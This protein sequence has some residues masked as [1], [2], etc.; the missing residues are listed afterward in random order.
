MDLLRSFLGVKVTIIVSL[1][2]FSSRTDTELLDK[3]LLQPIRDEFAN[4]VCAIDQERQT[5]R[6]Y[7][8]DLCCKIHVQMPS[9]EKIE[10][11]D[12]GCVDWTSKLLS[13]AKE[14]FV[15]SGIGS[16]RVCEIAESL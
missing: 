8:R 9:G 15:I 2:D 3:D 7:Y 12:G 11:A 14:R 4:V 1:T 10:V 5:G 16:K 13:N 6:G